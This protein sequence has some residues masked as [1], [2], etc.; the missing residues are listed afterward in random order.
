MARTITFNELRRIKNRLPEGSIHTIADKLNLPVQSVRNYFGGSNYELGTNMGFHL[1]PGP[2]GG[3]GQKP[4]QHT[5][6][7]KDLQ[8]IIHGIPYII[9]GQDVTVYESFSSLPE[10]SCL[11][12]SQ[13]IQQIPFQMLE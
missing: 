5:G 6:H 8:G 2:D 4:F 11:M 13:I 3:L 12:G 1:E 9:A 7:S 10:G